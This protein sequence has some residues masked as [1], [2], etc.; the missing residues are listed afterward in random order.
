VLQPVP[1][2]VPAEEVPDRF[3]AVRA[4]LRLL[5]PATPKHV[6][7][8]L[9]APLTDVQARWPDDAVEDASRAKDLRRTLGRPGGVLV[10]SE[11]AGTWRARRSGKA[12]TVSIELWFPVTPEVR[13]AVGGEAERLARFR[14]A[15]LK[16]LEIN[17]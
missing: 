9:D 1:G 3:D 11:I 16:S 8:H 10:G 12:V 13:A 17:A 7:G 14:N 4:Y 5:G 15:D 2:L 6:A